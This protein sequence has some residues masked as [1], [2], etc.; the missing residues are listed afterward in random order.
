MT[1]RQDERAQGAWETLCEK[2]KQLLEASYGHSK[3]DRRGFGTVGCTIV[4]HAMRTA[5]AMGLSGEDRYMLMASELLRHA[6]KMEAIVMDGE[7]LRP[8]APM[9]VQVEETKPDGPKGLYGVTP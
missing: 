3:T 8:P 9:F 6:D 2:R 4:R 5:D 7:M 1:D